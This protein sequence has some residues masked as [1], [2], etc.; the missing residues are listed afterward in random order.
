MTNMLEYLAVVLPDWAWNSIPWVLLLIAVLVHAAIF[1][2]M[3]R[4]MAGMR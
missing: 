4:G 3:L 2:V 1:T